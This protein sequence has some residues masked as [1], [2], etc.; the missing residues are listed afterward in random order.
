MMGIIV[1][2]LGGAVCFL[3]PIMLVDALDERARARAKTRDAR[4]RARRWA[5]PLLDE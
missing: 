5:S 3:A 2:I 4:K 1:S